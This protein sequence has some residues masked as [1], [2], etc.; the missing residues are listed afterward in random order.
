MLPIILHQAKEYYQDLHYNFPL[1][2]IV[3][4]TPSGYMDIYGWLKA[5]TQFYN[6]CGAYLVNNQILFFD[7][8]DSHFDDGALRI[9]IFKK[10]QPFVP[11]Y[12]NPT[13]DQPNYN[14]P[15]TKLKS[16]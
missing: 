15:N 10:I 4:H 8:H 11:K 16:L 9:M 7:G 1:G 13:N 5:M 6:I 2:W 3:H 12:G 14:G